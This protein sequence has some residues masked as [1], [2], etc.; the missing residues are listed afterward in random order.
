MQQ[1]T[2][3]FERYKATYSY[4]DEILG[5]NV[6]G[7]LK[8]K[9]LEVQA[10]GSQIEL[11]SREDRFDEL[12]D[13][14]AKLVINS[15]PLYQRWHQKIGRKVRELNVPNKPLRAFLEE[16]V[17]PFVHTMPT[18]E[19]SCGGEKGWSTRRN[20]ELHFPCQTVFSFDLADAF[21]NI[22]NLH[23]FSLFYKLFENLPEDER[24]G[25]SGFLSAL[26]T[27]HYDGKRGL[28]Q[29]S[30]LSMPLF[31]RVFYPIDAFLHTH[32]RERGMQYSR[33]VDDITLSSD[34][35]KGLDDFAGALLFVGDQFPVSK[36]K[37]YLQ[38]SKPIYFLGHVIDS[39][40][41]RKNSRDERESNKSGLLS[42]ED[43]TSGEYWKW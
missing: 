12:F 29:G 21:A 3:K 4:L 8:D 39:H 30:P 11:F 19:R 36:T 33:W 5:G 38:T 32:S 41:L 24:I 1:E 40:G 9:L 28:A 2:E 31:N 10:K 26:S 25:V 17:V 15:K 18:H 42:Y 14:V 20:A 16:F 35:K 23:I 37:T 27:V 7:A 34:S 13:G 22:G 6:P 43:I